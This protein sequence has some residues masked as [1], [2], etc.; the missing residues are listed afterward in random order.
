MKARPTEALEIGHTVNTNCAI[1][2]LMVET[3]IN[4]VLAQGPVEPRLALT[5]EPIQMADARGLV[6]TGA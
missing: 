6:L 5:V 3:F 4:V 1:L 2:T